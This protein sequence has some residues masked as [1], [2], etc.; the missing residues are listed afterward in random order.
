MS[1]HEAWLSTTPYCA[2]WTELHMP[3]I[4]CAEVLLN[5]QLSGAAHAVCQTYRHHDMPSEAVA[6][7]A[8]AAA[9]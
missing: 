1:I 8:A 7:A 9:S 5:P 4:K 6:A 2:L 3:R